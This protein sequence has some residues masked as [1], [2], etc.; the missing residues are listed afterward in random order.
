[1]RLTHNKSVLENSTRYLTPSLI[2]KCFHNGEL[3]HVD[4]QIC[5]NGFSSGF[6]NIPR[7]DFKIN[8][9][10]APNKAVLIEKQNSY[11]KGFFKD[12]RIKF[13]YQESKDV[14]FDKADVL[15]FVAD[16]FLLMRKKLDLIKHRIDKVL[17][18]EFHSVEIQSLHRYNLVDFENNVKSI[19]KN[20]NTSIVTVTA[21]PNLY[22]KVDYF[23]SNKYI[24]P[25]HIINSK[26]RVDSLDRVKLD[27]KKGRNVVVCTNSST[28]IY[29][30]KNYKNE[31]N[32][33]FI[34]GE[35]LTRSIVK[36]IK[37]VQNKKSN[38]TI[39]SS[40]GFEGFDL[41]Y[42]NAKIYYFEDRS[43]DYECF[44]ISNLYQAIN[45]NRNDINYI[46]YNRLEL[47]NSRSNPFNN[48]DKEIEDFVNDD[49]LS[50]EHKQT[51]KYKKYKPFLIFNQDLNGKFSLKKNE[52]SI[53]LFKEKLL[54]DNCNFIENFKEFLN[55]RQITFDA[56]NDNNNR[57][58]RKIKERTKINNLLSNSKM[59]EV[60]DLF[61]SKFN[62]EIKDLH[63]KTEGA[64]SSDIRSKYL[65]HLKEFLICKNFKGERVISEREN[66]ALNL[67]SNE[68]QFKSLVKEVTKAYNIRSIDKYGEKNSAKYRLSFKSQ[69][70]NVVCMF[71]LMF[72]NKRIFVPG[73]WIANRDYN[74]VTQ[75]GVN[76]LKLIG[77]KFN[78]DVME[79]DVKNCFPR[80]LY[81][82]NGLRLPDNFYGENKKNKLAI[83]VFLNDFFYNE[84]K[85][86]PYKIQKI[87]AIDKFKKYGFNEI[88]I[89]YLINNFFK[90]KF[91]GDL[92]NKLAFY[93]KN[94]ISEIKNDAKDRLNEGV[95]RRH[96][97]VLIFNNGSDL[98]VFNQFSYL[99]IRGWFEIKD[100][101]IIKLNNWYLEDGIDDSFSNNELLYMSI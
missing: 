11:K 12:V 28:V 35:S 34:I 19:F 94:I 58:K 52:V 6:I 53:N 93:E 32:A 18:D 2:E 51:S 43:N 78:V 82:L 20:T 8:I 56:F 4:K 75:I 62:I 10:I 83:N 81:A 54:F 50:I 29:K 47:S 24:R 72:A 87:R 85:L 33:N 22:S 97:S 66:I 80:V 90:N 84:S 31:V 5:G 69:S 38:L 88:V 45:R 44:Y 15:F 86:T 59:I 26:N 73:K 57:V 1:M 95:I 79:I 74:L 70:Y 89:N 48:I 27:I 25:L 60:L 23:I 100:Q 46:E 40:K 98:T 13:F 71:I 99:N 21:S 37:V 64:P 17:I 3:T 39:I 77:K 7:E 92:F 36:L 63:H 76:E 49:S 96:D 30:L 42:D 61:G 67:L 14:D 55:S 65:K 9:I 68:F 91:K 16:S 41:Y 101:N